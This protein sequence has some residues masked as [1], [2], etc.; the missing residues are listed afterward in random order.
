MANINQMDPEYHVIFYCRYGYDIKYKDINLFVLFSKLYYNTV[1][2]AAFLD[3][4]SCKCV[5]LISF[6]LF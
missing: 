3:L 2:R 4:I 1:L 6:V 5:R